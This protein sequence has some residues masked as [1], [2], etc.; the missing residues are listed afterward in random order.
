MKCKFC[1]NETD[2][3]NGICCQCMKIIQDQTM[4][5]LFYPFNNLIDWV[6][7]RHT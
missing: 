6:L 7:S 2:N 4:I 1:Q 3:T 5:N